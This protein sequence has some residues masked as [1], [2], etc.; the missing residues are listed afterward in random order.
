MQPILIASTNNGL[1][2][3]A[4]QRRTLAA[5]L[6]GLISIPAILMDVDGDSLKAKQI[7]ENIHREQLS[8]AETCPAVREMLA[9]LGKPAD[10]VAQLKKSKAWVSKHLT[11]TGPSFPAEVRELMIEGACQDL[12]TL[13][14]LGQIAKNADGAAALPGLIKQ[15]REGLI[16]RAKVRA[17]LD[18]LKAAPGEDEEGEDEVEGSDSEPT[19]RATITFELS[20]AQAQ[21]F[22]ALGGAQW[23]RKQLKKLAKA[24]A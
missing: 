1:A 8:L 10:V 9:M 16:G 5:K 15:V 4:G 7:V 12:G 14:I 21:Q 18:G 3:I 11:P 24:T 6:A 19:G 20:A 22:E 13:R 17:V 2:V 23:L